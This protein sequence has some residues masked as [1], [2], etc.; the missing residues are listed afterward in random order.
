MT[1]NNQPEPVIPNQII[2]GDCL[3]VMQGFKDNQF[4]LVL[5]DPPYGIGHL[6]TGGSSGGWANTRSQDAE[7]MNWDDKTPSQEYFDEIFRVSKHQI[8]W[9]GNYFVLP[10][11][12]GWLVWN[13]PERGFSLAEAELAW[14]SKDMVIRVGD[15]NRSE[16][17]RKHPTQK[18]VKL[19]KWCLVK[20]PEAKT[21]L[22]PFMGSGTTLRA[23][24]DLGLDGTGIEINPDYVKIAQDRLKQE[25]LL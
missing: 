23:C 9:G 14:T 16:S 18:P 19:F 12:R 2:L 5:T 25:V 17:D 20:F 15:F 10:V 21:I 24:K 22:D 7:R 6:S 3:E 4:D 13:K 1:P 8:I 11:S